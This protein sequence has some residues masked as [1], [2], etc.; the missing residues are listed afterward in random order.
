MAVRVLLM[1]KPSHASHVLTLCWP[2]GRTLGVPPSSKRRMLA[3]VAATTAVKRQAAS[4]VQGGVNAQIPLVG[5]RGR[6]RNVLA[7]VHGWPATR[8]S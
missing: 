7:V 2:Q 8:S 4:L 1:Y 3:W 6:V 5:S